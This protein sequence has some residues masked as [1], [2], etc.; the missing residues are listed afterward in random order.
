MKIAMIIAPVDFRD[1]EF[2]VPYNYFKDKGYEIDVFSTKRGVAKGKLGGEFEVEKTI[3]E[4]DVDKYDALVFVGGPGTPIVRKYDKI[5][6][7]IAKAH[8][9]NKVIGAICWSPT[10]LAKSGILKKRNATV[11]LGMDL[12]YGKTTDKVLEQYEARY[13]G[14]EIEVDKNIVTANGPQAALEYAKA[15]ERTVLQKKRE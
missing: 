12:E 11:W 15:I 9:K 3:D 8:T 2:F 1:E 4:M 14:K 13:S 7:K 10:I 5:Y 6:D